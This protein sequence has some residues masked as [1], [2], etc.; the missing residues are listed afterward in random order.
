MQMQ[1]IL[2]MYYFM[3]SSA[4]VFANI[5]L[6]NLLNILLLV[7]AFF[8]LNIVFNHLFLTRSRQSLLDA[9]SDV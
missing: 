7:F 4:K 1:V 5:D 9:I 6:C 8:N 2:S 3:L